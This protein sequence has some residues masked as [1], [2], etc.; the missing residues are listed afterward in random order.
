MMRR[1]NGKRG[2]DEQE[3]AEEPGE[4]RNTR[5]RHH[6]HRQRGSKQRRTLMQSGQSFDVFRARFAQHQRDDHERRQHGEQIAREVVENCRAA[7]A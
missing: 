2:L 7:V 3:F 5:E 4:R 1:T 6:R